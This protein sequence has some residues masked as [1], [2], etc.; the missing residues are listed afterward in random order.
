[1][2]TILAAFFLYFFCDRILGVVAD[3]GACRE[4]RPADNEIL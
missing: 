2:S 4:Q 3:Y 1:M